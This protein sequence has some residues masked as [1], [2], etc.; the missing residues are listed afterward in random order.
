M[1]NDVSKFK[2]QGDSTV[3]DFNDEDA[4]NRI[5]AIEAEIGDT[6]ISGVGDGSITGAIGDTDISGVGDGS[7]TGA[8]D[9][10]NTGIGTAQGD[11]SNIQGDILDIQGDVSDL[12]TSKADASTHNL[13][14]YT[15]VTQIGLTAGSATIA[16]AYAALPNESMLICEAPDFASAEV[17]AVTGT[18]EIIRS[19]QQA[20]G[21]VYFHGKDGADY[22]MGLN[23][24][25]LPG[26]TWMKMLQP[27]DLS[28][29][30]LV[31]GTTSSAVTVGA[32]SSSGNSTINVSVSGYTAL[33][34]VGFYTGGT[35]SGNNSAVNA[36]Y[37]SNAT[38]VTFNIINVSGTSRDWTLRVYVLYIKNS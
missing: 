28:S 25:N 33:C 7:I 29:Q 27:G 14:T 26:G 5:A 15:S 6:D 38:T 20:R 18:V 16:G 10:L 35:A 12:Q 21:W 30:F 36:C 2:V 9:E 1:A 19:A 11:I 34:V 32:N 13:K 8:I 31:R 17:P 4:E 22:R 37:L 23:A 3:Y 24:S